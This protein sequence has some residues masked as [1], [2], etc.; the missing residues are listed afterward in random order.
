[1]NDKSDSRRPR[2]VYRVGQEPD[3]RFSL[4]NERTFLA[5]CRTSLALLAAAVAL[6]ALNL[7]EH[8]GF[9][10][11]AAG[12]FALLGILAATEGLRGWMKTERALRLDRPLPGPAWAPLVTAGIIIAALLV[13]AGVLW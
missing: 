11:A 12:L 5:W 13:V 2:S 10:A 8:S 6:E 4:A 1:M 7:P 3:P 9:R